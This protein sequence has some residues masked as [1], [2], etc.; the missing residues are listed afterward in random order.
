MLENI[1]IKDIR[2]IKEKVNVKGMTIGKAKQLLS[3]F[4]DKHNLT[5]REALDIVN[6]RI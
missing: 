3:E 1:T 2:E 4:R 5:D 6:N